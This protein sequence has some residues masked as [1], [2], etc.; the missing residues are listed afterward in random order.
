MNFYA[1]GIELLVGSFIL[2]Q[3]TVRKAKQS[4]WAFPFLLA[5]FPVYYWLLTL[6]PPAHT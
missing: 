2:H 1:L 3:L 4:Q 6:T 5:T